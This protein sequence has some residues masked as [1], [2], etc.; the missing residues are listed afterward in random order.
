MLLSRRRGFTLVELLIAIVL[1]GVVGLTAIRMLQGTQRAASAQTERSALQATTRATA[2][3]IPAELREIDPTDPLGDLQSW[4]ALNPSFTTVKYRA[5]RGFGVVCSSTIGGTNKL[6]FEK[7]VWSGLTTG[8]RA[9]RDS[10]LIYADPDLTVSGDEIWVP[11]PI[12]AVTSGTCPSGNAAYVATV[13]PTGVL[14]A[15]ITNVGVGAPVR[16][17]EVME[18]SLYKPAGAGQRSWLGARSVS[19]GEAN[20]QPVLGPV[21]DGDGVTFKFLKSDGTTAAT[22]GAIRSMELQVIG[23][24]ANQVHLSNV[25]APT[26]VLDTLKLTVRFRNAPTGS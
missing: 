21:H 5:M 25:G 13:G 4:N 23:E 26:S 6:S 20:P 9:G 22:Q 3:I 8:P 15:A 12:T 24:T 16:T 10:I 1:M 11:L 19:A 14:Q 7:T 18:L 17:F 2:M